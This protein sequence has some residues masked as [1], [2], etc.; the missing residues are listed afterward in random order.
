MK[1]FG[2]F[3]HVNIWNHIPQYTTYLCSMSHM[4]TYEIICNIKHISTYGV[5]M[6]KKKHHWLQV[7]ASKLLRD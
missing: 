6:Y 3:E 2:T 1:S 4:P 5:L 7:S